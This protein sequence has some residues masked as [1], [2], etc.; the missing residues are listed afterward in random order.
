MIKCV[1]FAENFEMTKVCLNSVDSLGKLIIRE[2][3][4]VKGLYRFLHSKLRE[5]ENEK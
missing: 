5:R 3:M 1:Y 2:F 4:S